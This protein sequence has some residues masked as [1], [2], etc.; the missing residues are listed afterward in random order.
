MTYAEPMIYAS[1]D[2]VSVH[3]SERPQEQGR[4]WR[5][6]ERFSISL[7][8]LGQNEFLDT[9]RM[10]LQFSVLVV[11]PNPSATIVY[12]NAADKN[13]NASNM[14]LPMK[15]ASDAAANLPGCPAWGCPFF[16]S[17]RVTVPGLSLDSLCTTDIESQ[18]M[19]STRLL[20]SSG[21]GIIDYKIGKHS[22]KISGE[23]ELAGARHVVDRAGC[24]SSGSVYTDRTYQPYTS[25]AS[26]FTDFPAINDGGVSYRGCVIHYSVPLA[27]FSHLFNHAS[28]LLP[29]AFYSTASDT[30]T[31]TFEL[32]QAA[33]A[34]CDVGS[35]RP[36][37]AGQAIYY[38]IDPAI[39]MTKLQISNPATLAAIEQLFRGVTSI[40]IG[41]GVN[42]PVAMVMKFTNYASA[43]QTMKQP[44]G[45]FQVSIPANQPSCRGIAI[46]FHA[47]RPTGAGLYSGTVAQATAGTVGADI[48][49][50]SKFAPYSQTNDQAPQWTAKYLLTLRPLIRNLQLKIAS[51]RVPLDQLSEVR[52]PA[53]SAVPGPNADVFGG[54]TNGYGT[55]LD[56]DIS[57][58]SRE[59]AR[60]YKMGKHLFS[61]FAAEEHPHDVALAPFFIRPV[62][63]GVR[64]ADQTFFQDTIGLA[65]VASPPAGSDIPD[66]WATVSF[67][68]GQPYYRYSPQNGHKQAMVGASK[69]ALPYWSEPGLLIIPF[70]SLPCVYNHRDDAFALRGLDLRSIAS[71]ELSGEILGVAGGQGAG[72]FGIINEGADGLSQMTNGG[73][74]PSD[75]VG[76][77]GWTIRTYLAYDHEHVLL[78]GRVDPEAQFSLVPTGNTAIPSGGAGGM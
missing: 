14:N 50:W 17:V 57:T 5:P 7:R 54:L 49:R 46:R 71:M 74:N 13:G 65:N 11:V 19:I 52:Y 25:G 48:G 68:S 62:W 4:W 16:S 64:G 32:A 31:F 18:Y 78:P 10:R 23:A 76:C 1:R 53:G 75:E 9:N 37:M 22:F 20:C 42:V 66:V 47:D 63:N 30:C 27:F 51:F 38:V 60:L 2:Y 77:A 26:E 69:V 28:N 24:V 61:P 35:D 45:A 29:L 39:S 59:A 6:K 44:T 15:T 8:S 43:G 55:L 3:T 12:T 33:S 70:E 40:P 41:P 67:M 56:T 36:D 21:T 72:D 73:E 34:L 58:T